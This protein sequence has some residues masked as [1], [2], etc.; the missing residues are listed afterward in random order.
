MWG[1]VGGVRV[2][3]ARAV[4]WKVRVAGRLRPWGAVIRRTKSEQLGASTKMVRNLQD[5]NLCEEAGRRTKSASKP[6]EG[7][8]LGAAWFLFFG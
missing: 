1:G 4:C 2:R 3:T 7:F 8:A 6:H 5:R